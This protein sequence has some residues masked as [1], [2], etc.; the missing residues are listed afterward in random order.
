MS[1]VSADAYMSEM[2]GCAPK[3]AAPGL[4]SVVIPVYNG[5]PLLDH[6][7]VA[8]AAQDHA[9]E[10]EVI[11][12][13]NRSTDGLREHLATHPLA[14]RLA[15]RCV[16]SFGAQGRSHACNVGAAAA[17]GQFIV[18]CDADDAVHPGWLG[19]MSRAAQDF[20]AVGGAV[21]TR[22]LNTAAVASWRSMPNAEERFEHAGYLPYAIGCN[23][24]VWRSALDAVGGFDE[25]LVGGGEDAALSWSLQLAGFTLGHT[26][27]A[28][29]SY[30]F[31]DSRRGTWRQMVNYGRGSVHLYLRFRD[32]GLP[33]P[34]IRDSALG[35]VGVLVLNPLVPR[36][37][38]VPPRG[39][40]IA[41]TAF[42]TGRLRESV[43]LRVRYL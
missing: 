12:S 32:R 38:A 25:S 41:Q 8:L 40:W 23:L 3:A 36:I 30:R 1:D 27:E 17:R 22:A 39:M 24:G 18:F 35:W 13:D 34:S 20:D 2:S 10:F 37:G 9:G 33:R 15:L 21:E 14:E 6:Q 4:I 43:R 42:M 16:D 29:V 31:R 28:V 5:L 26:P 19:A 11:V 7:L